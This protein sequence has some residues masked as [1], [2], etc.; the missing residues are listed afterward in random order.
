M[1][2]VELAGKYKS[3]WG[4][5]PIWHDGA[6]LYVDIEGKKVIRYVEGQGEVD[7]WDVADSVGRVGTVVPRLNGGMLVAGDKGIFAL[8]EEGNVQFLADPEPDKANNR[9][10]DGKCSPDGHFFAGTISL[11]KNVGDAALYRYSKNGDLTE[12]YGAVTNSN[13][14]AWNKAG[15]VMFY[16]D[17]PTKQVMAFPYV[18]GELGVPKVVIDTSALDASPDGMAI[19]E[20]DHLWIAFCHGGCVI[21]YDPST[22]EQVRKVELPCLETTACAFGG[23]NL[24]VLYVTTGI[25]KTEVEEYAGRVL[26]VTGLGVCGQKSNVF[27]G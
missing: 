20:N 13:G 3:Q 17:T 26:K 10:N 7:C 23:E 25:H 1:H 6:L 9:F 2:Q 14:L 19:D 12:V 21:C 15:D 5:G 8:S 24:D 27:Q 22:G 18:D 16:I 11:V 4:E